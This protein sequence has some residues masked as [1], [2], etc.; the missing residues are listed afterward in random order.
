M[1][2]D[3]RSYYDFVK[4]C[5]DAGITVPIIPG[6]E[7]HCNKKQLTVLPK[8]F[9]I[10]LLADLPAKILKCKTDEKWRRWGELAAGA[11]K[12]S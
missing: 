2:F 5:R 11:I 1:F 4:A 10:D 3:N 8:T 6:L 7:T 12:G 9:H